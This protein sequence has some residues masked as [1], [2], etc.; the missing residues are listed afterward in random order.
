[1]NALALND[2]DREISEDMLNELAIDESLT[3]NF[4]QL[5]LN[6]LSG[7]QSADSI[8]LKATVLNKTMLILVDTGSSHCFVSSHFVNLNKLPTVPIPPQKVKLANGNW[9]A[10][11][12]QV[13]GLEWYIQG[14]T[15][16]TDMIVLDLLPYDAILGFN[17]L[18]TNSPMQCDW[19][20]K[21][22][23]FQHGT[24]DV[25]LQGIQPQP[26]TINTI[27]A[28]QIYKSSQGNDIWA[29][30]IVEPTH[31]V[32]TPDNKDDTTN[33]DIQLLLHQHADVFQQPSGLPP[34]RT[35]DHAIP[36]FPDAVPINSKPYHYSPQHKTEIEKQV[37]QLLESG[38]ITHSHSPFASPILLVKKKDGTWRFCVDYRKLNALTIKNRFPMPIVEEILDELAGSKY[39]TKLDMRSSYH[40]IRMLPADEYK[41]AFK[42]HQGHYQFK[43]MPFG[44]TNAP[45]TF[46]CI[47]NQL[48]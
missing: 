9:M 3:E 29:F 33:E 26:M 4:G 7:T 46:Q 23:Q 40:Q 41:T 34:Q 15:F 22:L 12:Q 19:Q 43:V 16:H 8:Q 17:W 11:T 1:V 6:A 24:K 48:L 13:K 10:A 37:Q 14:H 38:F 2:L 25:L 27:S 35:Y 30:V 36:L 32:P 18:K 20:A 44:L 39:F 28:K 45:A 42:T 31:S 5:S 21:T 47:M